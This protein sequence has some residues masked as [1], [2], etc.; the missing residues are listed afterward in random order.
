MPKITSSLRLTIL[1]KQKSLLSGWNGQQDCS[2]RPALMD[3]NLFAQLRLSMYLVMM[4][5][6]FYDKMPEKGKS[7]GMNLKCY[8]PADQQISIH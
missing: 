7:T 3:D 8:T 2:R 4:D 1:L 6:S 5:I